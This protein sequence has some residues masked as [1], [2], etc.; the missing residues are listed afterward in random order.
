MPLPGPVTYIAAAVVILVS[1]VLAAV[2]T[3]GGTAL[4]VGPMLRVDALSAATGLGSS[5][6]SVA[7][8]GLEL[9]KLVL[10]RADGT[11]EARS[12]A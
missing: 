7:L 5:E 10:K 9:K 1:G 8:M 6:V 11:F 12:S 2:R 3:T 4:T